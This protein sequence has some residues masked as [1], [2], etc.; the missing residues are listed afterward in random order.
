MSRPNQTTRT[1]TF[2]AG[3]RNPSLFNH[4]RIAPWA[5]K[6]QDRQPERPLTGSNSAEGGRGHSGLVFEI[7]LLLSNTGLSPGLTSAKTVE[8]AGNTGRFSEAPQWTNKGGR[9]HSRLVFEILLLLSSTGLSPGRETQK[10]G[11]QKGRLLA[12]AAREPDVCR[13]HPQ[14]I[15]SSSTV[16]TI[17]ASHSA[18]LL[19]NRLHPFAKLESRDAAHSSELAPH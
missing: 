9:G 17:Y 12:A 15:N 11:N 16:S 4:H 10:T 1:G 5:R 13:S 8:C 19:P 3:V 6:P 7:L 14:E 18:P 2:R